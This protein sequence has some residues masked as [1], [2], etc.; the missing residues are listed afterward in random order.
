M[1][2]ILS[3]ALALIVWFTGSQICFADE[4]ADLNNDPAEIGFAV[5]FQTS[6]YASITVFDTQDTTTGGTD[7]AVVAYARNSATGEIDT[8]GE[9]QVN[10]VVKAAEG[11]SI[12]S[13]TVVEGANNY[14]NMKLISEDENSACYRITKIKGDIIVSVTCVEKEIPGGDVDPEVPTEPETPET[15]EVVGIP[16]SFTSAEGAVI[17]V[18]ATKDL[19]AETATT[20]LAGVVARNGDT[21]EVDNTGDGQVNFTVDVQDGYSLLSVSVSEGAGNFKNIKLISEE[22]VNPAVYRITKVTG[23][24]TIS[25]ATKAEPKEDPESLINE[26]NYIRGTVTPYYAKYYT[27]ETAKEYA[28]F[29]TELD[30][31]DLSSYSAS[32]LHKVIDDL[33]L[34]ISSLTYKTSVV[35]MV[36]ISTDDGVGNY[37]VKDT[38]YVSTK[39]AI[40]DTDGTVLEDSASIKV[41][42]NST[43]MAPKKP[44]NLKFASKKNVLG[45]GSAKKWNL[46]AN[47]FD[48]SLM[49]NAI[50]FDIAHTLGLEYTSEITYAE[51]WVDGVYKGCY[52]LCEAVEAGSF[53]GETLYGSLQ[54][55]ALS[56]GK[57]SDLV[58][59]EIQEKYNAYL[60]QMMDGTFMK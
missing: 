51:V 2:R 35:P 4:I 1:K 5:S 44:F 17:T 3:V 25:V 9:G 38:G 33:S 56:A 48:A 18:Y 36:Y 23:P 19:N 16:V 28:D 31:R 42:G 20:D 41:R 12:E 7:N 27:E 45:M 6:D 21:G 58:P 40:V 55:G 50:A 43:A 60:Q 13:V 59:A 14:K 34:V 11:Y 8:T 52:Q 47:C 24:I 15:P 29:I 39:V 32:E 10:F 26:I 54:N 37:I 49:R 30:T 53:G 22:A 57:L 46:L